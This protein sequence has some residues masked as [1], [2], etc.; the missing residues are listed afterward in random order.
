MV[1]KVF[2]RWYNTIY[3]HIVSETF[4]KAGFSVRILITDK[5]NY[6]PTSERCVE[7]LFTTE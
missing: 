5:K 1:L 4:A 3:Q 2:S 6:K 7:T